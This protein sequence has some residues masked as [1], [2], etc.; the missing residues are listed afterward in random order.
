MS[1]L[2]RR[3]FRGF[4]VVLLQVRLDAKKAQ[5]RA[6]EP[7]AAPVRQDR[8][9]RVPGLGDGHV[10]V[11]LTGVRALSA[12]RRLQLGAGLLF[13]CLAQHSGAAPEAA[14]PASSPA[15]TRPARVSEHLADLERQRLPP[16]GAEVMRRALLSVRWRPAGP[17]LVLDSQ[18]GLLWTAHDGGRPIPASEAQAHC[19]ALGPGWKLL[20]EAELR[21]LQDP[22]FAQ[23][24]CGSQ[25]CRVSPL[26]QLSARIFWSASPDASGRLWAIELGEWPSNRARRYTPPSSEIRVLCLRAPER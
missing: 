5:P 9:G 3:R 23:M 8:P 26:F 1:T 24:P 17:G 14:V 2:L 10:H 22:G 21:A 20:G 16:D 7:W 19:Q 15:S 25:L 4:D 13:A 6:L 18:T 12:M 11:H